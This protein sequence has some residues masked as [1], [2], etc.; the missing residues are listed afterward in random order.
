MPDKISRHIPSQP[1]YSAEMEEVMMM[2]MMIMMMIMM[3]MMMMKGPNGKKAL[4]E[5]NDHRDGRFS[6]YIRP[7]EVGRHGLSIQYGGH[8]VPGSPFNLRVSAAPDPSKVEVITDY[9]LSLS[10]H[11]SCH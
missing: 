1:V 2:M 5:L 7:Q 9:Q 4:S 10:C 3:I 11:T 8:H 6:L